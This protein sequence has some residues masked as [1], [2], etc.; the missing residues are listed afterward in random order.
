MLSL[1]LG[2]RAPQRVASRRRVSQLGRQLVAARIAVKLVLGGIDL[3]ALTKVALDVC[4]DRLI[5][6]V[7]VQGRVR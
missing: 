5:A 2:L 1:K 4:A 6:A 3:R 7:S